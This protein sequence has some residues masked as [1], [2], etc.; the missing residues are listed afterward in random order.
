MILNIFQI[1]RNWFVILLTIISYVR[2]YNMFKILF[3]SIIKASIK[4]F[5]ILWAE[6]YEHIMKNLHLIF[7]Q[8]FLSF[9]FLVFYVSSLEKGSWLISLSFWSAFEITAQFKLIILFN[10]DNKENWW[11]HLFLMTW[12]GLILMLAYFLKYHYA[13]FAIIPKPS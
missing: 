11:S 13:S 9:N 6:N 2:K 8:I 3:K 4:K 5:W 12:Q 7:L 1:N 10:F